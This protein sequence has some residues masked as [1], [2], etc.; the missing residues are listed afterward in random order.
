MRFQQFA[1]R[2]AALMVLALAVPASAQQFATP[3]PSPGAKVQQTVGTTELSMSYSR[4]GV[5]GR[6]IWG[7]LVPW[8]QPWR[9]GAN[10]PNQFTC[11][12]EITVEGQKL[13]AG[14]Y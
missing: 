11:S 5:K 7:G 3:R 12:D 9:T 4:P 10:E 2:S 6:V 13:A 8:N 14:T 1:R